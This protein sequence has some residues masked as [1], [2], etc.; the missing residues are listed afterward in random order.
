MSKN[1]EVYPLFE[2][3]S[4]CPKCGEPANFVP[5]ELEEAQVD[6]TKHQC[7]ECGHEFEVQIVEPE[8]LECCSICGKNLFDDDDAAGVTK[9]KIIE[10]YHGF[11]SD[12]EPWDYV[13]CQKC[14]SETFSEIMSRIEEVLFYLKLAPKGGE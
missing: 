2:L 10:D 6:R 13:F 4:C 1:V 7:R 5:L 14:Y 3:P 8:P 9:G 12:S 11:G